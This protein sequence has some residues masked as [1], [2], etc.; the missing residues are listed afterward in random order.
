MSLLGRTTA[1]T[2]TG[3]FTR[4]VAPP[5]PPEQLQQ[6]EHQVEALEKVLTFLGSATPEQQQQLFSQTQLTPEQRQQMLDRA[7]AMKQQKE[8][9]EQE[10]QK[11]QAPAPKVGS[12]SP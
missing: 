1:I 6:R 3:F 2:L 7:R 10:Q 8:Q 12:V 4:Q 9:E 11:L 5:S